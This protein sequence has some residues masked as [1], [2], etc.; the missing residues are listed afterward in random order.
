MND[1]VGE[2]ADVGV[3]SKAGSGSSWTRLESLKWIARSRLLP[4]SPSNLLRRD[5]RTTSYCSAVFLRVSYDWCCSPCLTAGSISS[6][7]ASEQLAALRSVDLC[8]FKRRRRV[9]SGPR[10]S[11]PRPPRS[12]RTLLRWHASDRSRQEVEQQPESPGARHR[13]SA[14]A[15]SKS[16][17]AP[18]LEPHS[19]AASHER[20][21]SAAS[22][23]SVH[24]RPSRHHSRFRSS[25]RGSSPTFRSD[26]TTLIPRDCPADRATSHGTMLEHNSA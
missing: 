23:F 22:T 24:L 8:E 1:D 5:S 13:F 26:G 14:S 20:T 17:S 9:A 7:T 10:P 16:S 15:C 3:N 19:H 25:C 21:G 18:S 2:R 12:E 6:S 11:L 4:A